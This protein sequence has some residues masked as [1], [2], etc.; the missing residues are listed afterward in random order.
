MTVMRGERH[1]R[2]KLTDETVRE[3]RLA[4]ERGG[5]THVSLAARYR[6]HPS[7]IGA[8]LRGNRWRHVL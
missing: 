6:V 3:I 4:Y 1:P 2:H 5:C 7:L 8:V